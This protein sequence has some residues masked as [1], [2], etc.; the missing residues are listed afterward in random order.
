MDASRR[1]DDPLDLVAIDDDELPDY[2]PATA[3]EY[4]ID[5]TTIPLHTYHLRQMS[6]KHQLFVPYGPSA[7]SSY[8]A[9]G[10]SARLFS[11]KADIDVWR[12]TPGSVKEEHISG[13]W[14]DNNGPL[15]WCPRAHFSYKDEQGSSTHG[16]ESRNFSDWSIVL[17]GSKCMWLLAAHGEYR[18]GLQELSS[19][20]VIAR[21]NFSA[22]GTAASGGAEAG[23]LTIYRNA[24]SLE[25]A[26]SVAE[27][28]LCGLV[29]AL[30]NFRKMGKYYRSFKGYESLQARAALVIGVGTT[31]T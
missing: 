23:N 20:D 21:F 25:N 19:G 10:R 14:F 29:V 7:S 11:K 5:D 28:I 6:R 3:P 4:S 18:M 12:T 13:I 26:G 1:C 2:E 8:R 17:G 30:A 24:L 9:L 15:P 16:M 22:E 27:K 31:S